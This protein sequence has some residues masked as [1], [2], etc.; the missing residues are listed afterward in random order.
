L[1]SIVVPVFNGERYLKESLDSILAQTYAPMEIIVMDD[2]SA[3]GTA[4][5]AQ[6]YGSRITYY[7]QPKNLGQFENVNSGIARARGE[8]VGVFH[9]DDVYLP[10]IVEREVAAFEKYP[11]VGA[12]FCQDIFIDAQGEEY[13]RLTLP[14]EVRGGTPLPFETVWNALLTHQNRFLVCPGAMVRASVYREV[15]GYRQHPWRESADLEM[16]IRIARRFPIVVLEEY[17]MKYR[18]FPNQAHRQYN[19]LRT[20]PALYFVMTDGFLQ[21]GCDRVAAPEALRAY[22]GH[23]AED[24]LMN[25]VNLYIR[26]DL[27][28]ARQVLSSVRPGVLLGTDRIDRSRMMT[29]LVVLLLLTRLPRLGLAAALFEWR[30]QSGRKIGRG[31]PLRGLGAAVG[32]WWRSRRADLTRA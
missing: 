29:L 23:R 24:R 11:E 8:L 27:R 28:G 18:H 12:V 21:D 14:E 31:H 17:L 4:R 9:A 5:I 2:G 13:G 32:T 7:R 20:E 16:W 30:W 10:D 3:D 25:V 26:G 22:E 1:V 15:G 6:S 19:R